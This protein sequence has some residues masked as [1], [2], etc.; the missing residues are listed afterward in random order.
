MDTLTT[1][2]LAYCSSFIT[3]QSSGNSFVEKTN[4]GCERWISKFDFVE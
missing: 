1:I 2:F 4:R 3:L